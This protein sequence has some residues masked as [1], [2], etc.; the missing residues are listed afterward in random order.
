[1][2][3]KD[4]KPKKKFV[5]GYP[6]S[7]S[8]LTPTHN[9]GFQRGLAILFPIFSIKIKIFSYIKIS[10]IMNES[11]IFMFGLKN[12]SLILLMHVVVLFINKQTDRRT[13][14]Q[15]DRSFADV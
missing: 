8:S 1:M 13:D 15:T 7:P 9:W 4:F 11:H 10:C 12:E 6:K 14:R 5:S 2:N 3:K